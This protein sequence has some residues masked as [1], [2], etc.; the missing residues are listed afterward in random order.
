VVKF[1]EKTKRKQKCENSFK[2]YKHVLEKIDEKMKKNY[3]SKYGFIR[4]Y[5]FLRSSVF[6][7]FDGSKKHFED[8]E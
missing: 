6:G 8:E 5:H 7:K 4:M 3:N 1:D 2:S